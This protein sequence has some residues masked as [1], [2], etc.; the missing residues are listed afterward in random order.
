M[1]FFPLVAL[2]GRLALLRISS[3]SRGERERGSLDNKTLFGEL[4]FGAVWSF[5]DTLTT[6]ICSR[7][8]YVR[9]ATIQLCR[10]WGKDASLSNSLA[11]FTESLELIFLNYQ[12]LVV[13]NVTSLGPREES[14]G[15]C[16][17]LNKYLKIVKRI[18]I[19]SLSPMR[20]HI[21][22]EARI[23]GIY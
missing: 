13:I 16:K 21:V 22:R 15:N 9:K 11:T 10:N 6:K 8:L 23:K 2:W 19:I 14:H 3:F 18:Q 4:Q 12:L 20:D 5:G 7:F 17:A 1:T